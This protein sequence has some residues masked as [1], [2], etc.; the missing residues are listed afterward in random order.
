M[1]TTIQGLPCRDQH[2]HEPTPKV[3]IAMIWRKHETSQTIHKFL[4]IV[5]E[6][7]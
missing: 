6:V 7:K 2:I 3:A 5:R 1:K 4:E